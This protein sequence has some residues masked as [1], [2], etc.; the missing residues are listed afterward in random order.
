MIRRCCFEQAHALDPSSSMLFQLRSSTSF[1]LFTKHN[2]AFMTRDVNIT[3]AS[4]PK[5][6]P[7][8]KFSPKQPMAFSY[9]HDYFFPSPRIHPSVHATRVVAEQHLTAH[10]FHFVLTHTIRANEPTKTKHIVTL[11]CIITII[12]IIINHISLTLAAR[13]TGYFRLGFLLWR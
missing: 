4:W 6:G 3:W 7:I 12:I 10:H 1:H 5:S 13:K 9:H 2:L 8:G 11:S